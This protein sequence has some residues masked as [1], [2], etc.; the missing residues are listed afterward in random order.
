MKRQ[1]LADYRPNYP[2]KILKGAAITTASV[3]ALGTSVACT[4]LKT[5]GVAMP[6]DDLQ[7]E[8]YIMPE[9][10]PTDELILEGEVAIDEP[11]EELPALSGVVM[12][13]PEIP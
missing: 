1:Q 2:K 6:A 10:D 11:T 5:G 4:E 3:L 8:G 7:I 12:T 13:S 9:P